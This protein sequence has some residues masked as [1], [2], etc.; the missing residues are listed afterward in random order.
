MNRTLSMLMAAAVC[1]IGAGC[2]SDGAADNGSA[3]PPPQQELPAMKQLVGRLQSGFAGIGGEHTGWVMM[4]PDPDGGDREKQV[5]VDVSKVRAAAKVNDGQ[6]VTAHGEFI[7]K[8]YVERGP[9]MIFVVERFQ[10][11]FEPGH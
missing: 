1:A 7:E 4:V 8:R 10:T 5:E 3:N 2:A 11:C 9:T 6:P